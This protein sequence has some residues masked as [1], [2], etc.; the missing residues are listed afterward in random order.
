MIKVSV[1]VPVYK[2]EAYIRRCVESILAQTE[3]DIELLLIDDGSPDKSGAICD[4]YSLIDER[5]R[6]F[7]KP[8]GG[9]SSA[10]NMGIANARGEYS[11]H[12]DPDDW[13]DPEMVASLYAFA[14][15]I[16]ADVVVCDFVKE[17][18]QGS[19]LCPQTC[20]D[21]SNFDL[22]KKSFIADLHGS[23]CNKLIR[24]SLYSKI[25]IVIPEDLVLWEDKYVCCT[26]ANARVRFSYLNRALY[27]YDQ[28]SNPNSLVESHSISIIQSQTKVIDYIETMCPEY[29]S[30]TIKLKEQVLCRAYSIPGF[31]IN[32]LFPEVHERFLQDHSLFSLDGG[33]A[34]RCLIL[35]LSGWSKLS[36][37]IWCLWKKLK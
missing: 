33:M 26:L 28:V 2:A 7:H 9:V 22:I 32:M 4:E 20:S 14:Y 6:V 27:H 31:D 12:V 18:K 19:I 16:D 21:W 29:S 25:G 17:T 11:I 15:D 36:N 13:I 24:H 5:V 23:L 37:L 8:N 3:T 1:I 30:E 10:R 34:M 35:Q